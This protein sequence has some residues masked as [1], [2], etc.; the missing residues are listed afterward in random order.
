MSVESMATDPYEVVLN[1]LRA[2]KAQIEQA[3][4]AIE[5]I[6]GGTSSGTPSMASS[7]AGAGQ[8]SDIDSPGAFLG[9]SIVDAAK[10]LLAAKRQPLRNPDIAAAFKRGGLAMNSKDAVNTIGSVLTR[11][12]NDVGDLV[13]VDRG[14]W[15]LKEWYPNR[16]FRKGAAAEKGDPAGIVPTSE[17]AEG[18][19]LMLS[20]EQIAKL[21]AAGMSEDEI[22][23]MPP[24][25]ASTYLDLL[26]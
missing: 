22:R 14:T 11:R 8:N 24:S 2:K 12:A 26:A 21:K 5:A 4:S 18:S 17:E 6:R 10:K 13:K 9:M 7:A 16:N 15:G 19:T 25:E 1:D 23:A 3:I 20:L